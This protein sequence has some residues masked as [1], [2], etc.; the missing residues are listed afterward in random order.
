[1]LKSTHL[2][3]KCPNYF[4]KHPTKHAVQTKSS[5]NN[6]LFHSSRFIFGIDIP[7]RT[8]RILAATTTPAHTKSETK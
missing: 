3:K 2:I 8:A 7:Y 4:A 1:M 5:T 6:D